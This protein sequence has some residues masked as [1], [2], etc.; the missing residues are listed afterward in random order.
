ML[1]Y[2]VTLRNAAGRE[3]VRT[4][5]AASGNRAAASAE[6]AERRA[7]GERWY[8]VSCEPRN[9]RAPIQ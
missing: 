9:T 8:C 5:H 2:T 3:T 7:T 6:R 4:E 1:L